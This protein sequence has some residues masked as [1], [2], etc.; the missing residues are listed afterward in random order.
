MIKGGNAG[1][2]PLFDSRFYYH[3]NESSR[4]SCL[5][6]CAQLGRRLE[7]LHRLQFLE[8]GREHIGEAPHGARLKLFILGVKVKAVDHSSEVPRSSQL[9]LDERTVD[10]QFGRRGRE[11]LLTPGF[12]LTA[13]R[14]E[15]A[16]HSIHS[17]RKAVLK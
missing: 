2:F 11:L 5:Q 15:I 4:L 8:G 16:L 7:L 3:P 6:E 9:A 10:D 17:D 14:V 1:A 13:H 12:H